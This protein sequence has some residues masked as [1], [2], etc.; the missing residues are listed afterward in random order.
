MWLLLL[1][2]HRT[3]RAL[4]GPSIGAGLLAANWKSSAMTNSPVTSDFFQSIDVF[5]NLPPQLTLNDIGV[6]DHCANPAHLILAEITGLHSRL[7]ACSLADLECG[8]GS[9]PKDI[10]QRHVNALIRWDVNTLNPW[11]PFDPTLLLHMT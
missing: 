3:S 8:I 1:L 10:S 5:L 7:D 6:L 2:R 4:P 11:H 9:Y